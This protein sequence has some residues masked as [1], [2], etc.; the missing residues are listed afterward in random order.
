MNN[1]SIM[2]TLAQATPVN[3]IAEMVFTKAKEFGQQHS[4]I[5]LWTVK[6]LSAGQ[7]KEYILARLKT[8]HV[9]LGIYNVVCHHY[10]G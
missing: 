9:E 1:M 2:R 10:V 5:I 3:S 8:A 6:A 7:K 4:S